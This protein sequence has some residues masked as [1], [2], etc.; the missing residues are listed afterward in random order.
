MSSDDQWLVGAHYPSR[1]RRQ[2]ERRHQHGA[3]IFIY[4]EPS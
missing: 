1:D 2:E 4:I 3:Y